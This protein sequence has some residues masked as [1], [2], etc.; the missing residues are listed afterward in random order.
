VRCL[1]HS[2]L[3]A[4]YS[5]RSGFEAGASKQI[6]RAGGA[7]SAQMVDISTG[8]GDFWVLFG[9]ATSILCEFFIALLRKKLYKSR[10]DIKGVSA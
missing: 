5:C 8:N 6:F 2:E 7:S 1:E 4:V 9:G 10:L 3:A